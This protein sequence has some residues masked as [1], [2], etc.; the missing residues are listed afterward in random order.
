MLGRQIRVITKIGVPAEKDIIMEKL[1]QQNTPS[2]EAV[3]GR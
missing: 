3:M 1:Q 2:M